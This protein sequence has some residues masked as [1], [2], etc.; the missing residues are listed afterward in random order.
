MDE[1]LVAGAP[2][3]DLISQ[4]KLVHDPPKCLLTIRTELVRKSR[5]K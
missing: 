4:A 3:T 1:G 5:A 2:G